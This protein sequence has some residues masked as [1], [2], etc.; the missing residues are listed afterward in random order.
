MDVLC[1][2]GHAVADS[3]EVFP[4]GRATVYRNLVRSQPRAKQITC[5]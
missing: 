4:V 5:E 1:V 2:N 3:T